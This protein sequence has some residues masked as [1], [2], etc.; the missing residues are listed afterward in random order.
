MPHCL[1][2][3]TS[4]T[5]FSRLRT[6]VSISCGWK[7]IAPSPM[8]QHTGLPGRATAAP[9]ACATPAPSMPKWNVDSSVF[10]TRT[11]WKN[12]VQIVELP[13]SATRIASSSKRRWAT[14]A[15]CDGFIGT[16]ASASRSSSL[17][18]SARIAS[19]YFAT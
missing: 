8:M 4:Q 3:T 18:R 6:A 16:E 15:T 17:A 7:P 19:P 10:G 2:Q 1:S 9:I 5:I 13:P 11:W 14:C 12:I